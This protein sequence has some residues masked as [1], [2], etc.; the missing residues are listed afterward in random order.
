M[1]TVSFENVFSN[2]EVPYPEGTAR[3][4]PALNLIFHTKNYK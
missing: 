4:G 1:G 2:E 3:K